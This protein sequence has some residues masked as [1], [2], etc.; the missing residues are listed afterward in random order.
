MQ[1]IITLTMNPTIDSNTRV[2]H[3]VNNHK[4]RCG[5]PSFEPGGGGLNVSRVI[6]RLGGASTAL[7]TCGGADGELLKRLLNEENIQH[8]PIPIQAMT[9]RNFTVTE[10]AS[11]NQYRFGV[12]GPELQEAEW[13]GCLDKLKAMTTPSAYIVGSGSLPPGVPNDFYT[14]VAEIAVER[15]ARLILDSSSEALKLALHTGVYLLKPNLCELQEFV[16]K[17]ITEEEQQE[18][19]ARELIDQGYSQ[20]IVLS[21]GNAG[22]LLV[23]KTGAERVRSPS[24]LIK[25]RIGAG[26]SMVAGLVFQLA[27]GKS[28]AEAGR[29][30]IA[31]GAAAVMT[32]GTELCRKEDTAR[33]YEQLAQEH[34]S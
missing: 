19:F 29:F 31:A 9:R 28:F 3:V 10:T 23:S 33:L 27:Q 32:P 17:E 15:G 22:A 6:H 8:H 2:S 20:Y 30:G 11:G 12:P 16:E 14:R 26:D 1:T 34:S 13:Q 24:V 21:L 18:A 4:L 25:S 7:Y 5:S